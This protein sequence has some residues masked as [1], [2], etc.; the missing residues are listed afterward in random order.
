M[1][2]FTPIGLTYMHSVI[3]SNLYVNHLLKIINDPDEML[4]TDGA[5]EI[6][7]SI[8][9]QQRLGENLYQMLA[10]AILNF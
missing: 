8:S 5:Y 10:F 1:T 7:N 2:V 3:L 4:W 6:K 9:K